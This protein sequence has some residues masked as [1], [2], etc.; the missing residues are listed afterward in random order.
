M[1]VGVSVLL[2][3]TGVI[4]TGFHQ[5]EKW[6][7]LLQ[8]AIGIGKMTKLS[9]SSHQFERVQKPE[10]SLYPDCVKGGATAFALL[11]ESHISVHTWPEIGSI[12]IDI[13]TCGNEM[14]LPALVEFFKKTLPHTNLNQIQIQ[15]GDNLE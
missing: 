3:F 5:A 4:E 10:I 9:I 14:N 7:D 15:R 2:D 6:E 13:F 1:F 8:Q 11:A 12:V